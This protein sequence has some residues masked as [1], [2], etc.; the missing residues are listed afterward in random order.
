MALLDSLKFATQ[1]TID[2]R[3]GHLLVLADFTN[4]YAD[5]EIMGYLQ[6]DEAKRA[7]K[8]VNKMAVVGITGLK[9]MF[10]QVYNTMTGS[11][12]RPCAD[13]ESAK[14]YLIS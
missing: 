13:L 4:T 12:A 2:D 9:K 8:N 3:N 1:M 7:A 10:L 5:N 14:Q 6:S 11:I